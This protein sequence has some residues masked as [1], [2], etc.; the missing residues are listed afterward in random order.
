ME[1]LRVTQYVPPLFFAALVGV[2]GAVL[3][4]TVPSVAPGRAAADS[5]AI[6]ITERGIHLDGTDQGDSLLVRPGGG[7][8]MIRNTSGQL[9]VDPD[10]IGDA[11]CHSASAHNVVCL[12]RRPRILAARLGGGD[13]HLTIRIRLQRRLIAYG[14][15]GEDFA[16]PEVAARYPAL[17]VGGSGD[18]NL[19]G[20]YSRDRLLGGAGHDGLLGDDGSDVVLGGP[21]DDDLNTKDSE[22]DR[23]ISC[24]SGNGDTILIDRKR[25]PRPRGCEN[26]TNLP[27]WSRR[28]HE[29]EAGPE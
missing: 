12:L 25:D 6:R 14:G 13:D 8:I 27:R 5:V 15:P 17:V 1:W 18:D 26:P 4:F 7:G 16:A 29:A 20:G 23:R 22:A 2:V 10:G 9:T 11:I 19:A 3:A 21:G 28:D 24:G